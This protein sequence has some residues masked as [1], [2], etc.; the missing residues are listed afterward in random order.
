MQR[1]SK[2]K[3]SKFE[4]RNSKFGMCSTDTVIPNVMTD[5]CEFFIRKIPDFSDRPENR[6]FSLYKKGREHKA[7]CPGYRN[8]FI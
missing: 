4:I 8:Y 2:D 3:N 5:W 6:R 1:K 7:L